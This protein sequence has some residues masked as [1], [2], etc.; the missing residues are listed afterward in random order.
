MSNFVSRVWRRR[1]LGI[2]LL[3]APAVI[4]ACLL[5]LRRYTQHLPRSSDGAAASAA[6]G[7]VW[8]PGTRLSYAYESRVALLA[9][10][11]AGG[12]RET[13]IRGIY[14]LHVLAHDAESANIAVQLTDPS[15]QGLAGRG[16]ELERVLRES[17]AYV[18]ATRSGRVLA[19]STPRHLT[20][21]DRETLTRLFRIQ[22][23]LPESEAAQ[24]EPR[25]ETREHDELGEYLAEYATASGG[26]IHKR[27]LRYTQT[28]MS[29]EFDFVIDGSSSSVELGG[30]WLKALH[31]EEAFR[32]LYAGQT[33]L[34][35]RTTLTLTALPEVTAPAALS[36]L[37]RARMD[38]DLSDTHATLEIEL[39][40]ESGEATG[41][42][43]AELTRRYEHVPLQQV[44]DPLLSKVGTAKRH[45]DVLPELDAMRDWLLVHPNQAQKLV[46]ALRTRILEPDESAYLVHALELASEH[47]EAQIALGELILDTTLADTVRVQ[48]MIAAGGVKRSLDPILEEAL[49]SLAPGGHANS[50]LDSAALLNLG[51]LANGRP[52]VAARLDE[53]YGAFLEAAAAES[54]LMQENVLYALANGNIGGKTNLSRAEH[55]L[56][57]AEDSNVRCAAVEYLGRVAESP[58]EVLRRALSDPSPRVQARAMDALL[59]ERYL[60]PANLLEVAT[61]ARRPN[62]ADSV[63]QHAVFSLAKH[64]A[65]QPALREAFVD[66][67]AQ[68][69]SPELQSAIDAALRG[70]S[71]EQPEPSSAG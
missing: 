40:P 1:S 69:N 6:S 58:P 25:W 31:A 39:S 35:A 29:D 70:E 65:K 19:V 18:Q 43:L 16:A 11:G 23:V 36:S 66:I 5:G 71:L 68:T 44:L 8:Q 49:W 22:V 24:A 47:P 17:V 33:L 54:P 34:R 67:R 3:L 57:T 26:R 45:A 53:E 27:R 32:T 60:G 41:S 28:S 52:D 61:V 2:V 9:D 64:L 42:K 30:T 20:R 63:R 55:L 48:A 12:A 59:S 4:V 62:T 38:A 56:R 14:H 51:V 46:A 13:V 50:E 21:E 15:V 10:D 37:T 7:F